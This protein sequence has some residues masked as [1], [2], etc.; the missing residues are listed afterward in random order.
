MKIFYFLGLSLFPL[1][2]YLRE[3]KGEVSKRHRFA[4]MLPTIIWSALKCCLCVTCFVMVNI[5]TKQ[6]GNTES[7]M[8]NI[9][10]S[11]EMLKTLSVIVQSFAYSNTAAAILRNFQTP[12]L[13]F[14]N[15]LNRP[16]SFETFRRAF[17]TKVCLAFGT[18]VALSGFFVVYYTSLEYIDMPLVLIKVMSF[19]SIGVYVKIVFYID[20]IIH[21]L[22]H[23]N[24]IIAKD[25]AE[26]TE[27]K[28]NL[29]V[30]RKV[31]SARMIR[32]RLFK[33]KLIHFHLWRITEQVNE[34]FGWV[35]I[36]LS[37]Q[38]FVDL[39]YNTVWQLRVLSEVWSFITFI[40]KI[41]LQLEQCTEIDSECIFRTNFEFRINWNLW[42]NVVRFQSQLP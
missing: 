5:C 9:F 22:R 17:F 27:K 20:L 13:L 41:L 26:N 11:C 12:E 28:L 10:L 4:L 39:V 16:I 35:L 8:T 38:S 14:E 23:L 3:N 33:Y 37:L 32:Q 2:Y 31:R 30:V 21:N 42:S 19:I 1:K 36:A 6:F 24:L 34:C 18:Y 29:F 25:I 15:I 7:V 40:R